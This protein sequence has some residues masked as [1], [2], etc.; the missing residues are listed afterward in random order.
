MTR[1]IGIFGCGTI[2]TEIARAIADGTLSADLAVVYDRHPENVTAIRDLFDDRSQP[3]AATQPSELLEA[4]LVL[5]AAGQTAVEEIAA[6]ALAADRDCLLLSVGALAAD[7]LREDVFAA[8]EESDGRLYAP[9]GAIAGLD[10]I[11]AAALTGDLESVSLTTTKPPAGLEGAPYV[12]E[13]GIDLSAVDEPTVIFEGPATEAAAAF[14]SNINV[15]VALSLA[16]IGPDETAV[17]IV[18]DPDEE[19]N[20]HRISADGDMG[21]IETTVQNVP[22]PTNPKTSYLAAISAIEKLRSLETAIDVGT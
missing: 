13:N 14:P 4:D 11:K 15:A 21:H 8:A 17:R 1:S 7:D 3:T 2:A 6:D 9:S 12:V 10:A 19:N 20:V 16:G 5:E 22:S 18:A